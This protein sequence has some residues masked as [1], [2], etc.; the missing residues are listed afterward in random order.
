[1]TTCL[2]DEWA[3][4]STKNTQQG[5]IFTSYIKDFNLAPDPP[6]IIKEIKC[7]KGQLDSMVRWCCNNPRAIVHGVVFGYTGADDPIGATQSVE[8]WIGVQIW[9]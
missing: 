8:A 9:K 4:W 6:R 2:Y 5:E 3:S 7:G 1:M